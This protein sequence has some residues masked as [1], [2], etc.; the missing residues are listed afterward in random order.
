[1]PE[2]VQ[3]G[4]AFSGLRL[5]N[6]E[7][8]QSERLQSVDVTQ[9]QPR[10]V[11]REAQSDHSV[12]QPIDVQRYHPKENQ[13]KFSDVAGMPEP[14]L[15]DVTLPRQPEIEPDLFQ[16]EEELSEVL[17][18]CQAEEVEPAL[19]PVVLRA[20]EASLEVHPELPSEVQAEEFE[21]EMPDDA[22]M[23][24]SAGLTAPPLS[25]TWAHAPEAA[26]SPPREMAQ[27][28]RNDQQ[29]DAVLVS[30]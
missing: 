24:E 25:R 10:N 5:K 1:M 2:Q 22:G 29:V 20:E 9:D 23:P 21:P 15:L 6:V 16:P 7:P 18:E 3:Q 19:Q 11:R 26:S 27:V 30:L 13:L 4:S 12:L 14:A 17:P 28:P 8:E